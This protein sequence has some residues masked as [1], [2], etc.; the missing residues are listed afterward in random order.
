[1]KEIVVASKN[2]GKVAEIAAALAG[3]PV[4]VLPLDS[5]GDIPDAVESGATFA[6]NAIAKAKHYAHYTARA[7]LADDSGLEV[8][9]LAG[10]PGVYSARYAGE[11]A[12]DQANNRKL[13]A[14]LA[15]VAHDKRTAR[16][17]C[18]LA[19]IDTDSR[20]ITADGVCEGVILENP[21]G[22]GGFGY[23]PLFYIPESSRTLA[24]MSLADK[25]AISHRGQAL[26]SIADKL[27]VYL[28]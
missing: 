14:N 20:I 1:M 11:K 16:F 21:Q 6:D 3:L 4:T 9:A 27:K 17:R 22:T 7:C 24:E 19:F 13:L 26:R 18:V 23:D 12:D 10:A 8:D 25:N 2:K 5:F 15:G 28:K